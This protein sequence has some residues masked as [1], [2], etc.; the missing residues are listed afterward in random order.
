MTTKLPNPHYPPEVC[1]KV[2]LLNFTITPRGL[3]DQMLGVFVVTEIP[4]MEERKNSLTLANSRMKKE[5]QDVET[6]I[7]H[8]LSV[9]EGNVLDDEDLIDTLSQAKLTSE[10]ITVKVCAG[11]SRNFRPRRRVFFGC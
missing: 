9:F 3:E 7:L 5:L 8:L 4:E 6:R 2:S 11:W 10:E 1:V